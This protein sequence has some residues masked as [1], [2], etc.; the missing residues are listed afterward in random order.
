M[1]R[2]APPRI[3]PTSVVG[4]NVELAAGVEIGPLCLLDGKIRIGART[5]LIG[6]VTI[7]GI[8]ELGADNVLHPGAV[9]GDEPQD[10]TYTGVARSVKIGD[11]NIFREY[12]TVHRGCEH[13]D[14]TI[15]G[16]DNFMMQN[17]HV[18]HDCR[19]GNSTIIAG[20]ALLAGWVELGD[21][22]LVSG[23]C[24]V[25]QYTRIG[26]LAMMRGL[27]RTS[28]D[29]PPFCIMDDTHT[30]RGINVVGLKRAGIPL[31]SIHALRHAFTTLFG[32]RQ[33]LKLAIER[34]EKSGNLTVEVTE[35]LN[36]IKS[37]KRGVAFGPQDPHSSNDAESDS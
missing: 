29:V 31:K 35:L 7:L 10:L 27:S 26:R 22:A 2:D 30:L 4:P 28:R 14:V 13:G 8:T 34:L 12:T 19:I 11:R 20:G 21:R 37:S 16:N 5:R 24:V 32:T 33:N 18:A 36:F 1:T 25:H 15:M 23:N 9:I 6:H 3:H 17:A